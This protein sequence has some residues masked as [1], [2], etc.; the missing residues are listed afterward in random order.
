MRKSRLFAVLAVL[1]LLLSACSSLPRS[2]DVHAVN[3]SK[4]EAGN[5]ALVGQPPPEGATPEEIV[6]Y[7]LVACRAGGEDDYAVARQ[8]LMRSTSADWDPKTEV[9]VYP[10][11]QNIT[12]TVTENGGVKARVG[13]LGTLSETG[14]Y[15]ESANNAVFTTDFSLAKNQDGEW[16][17]ASLEDGIFLAERM[18]FGQLYVEAPVYFLASATDSLVA[19]LH[20]FP[21][22]EAP[23]R[24]LHAF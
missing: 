21:R 11:N 13:S 24:A 15:T 6:T 23:S 2:G 17:I 16:R 20:W 5:V 14:V 10:D 12:T 22:R 3:P 4:N 8:Y 1:G 18:F 7:F 19:D 9:R